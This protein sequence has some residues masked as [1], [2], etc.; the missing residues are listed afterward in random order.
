MTADDVLSALSVLRDAGA[1]VWV[2]GGWGIDALVG[3]QTRRHRD[4]DLMHRQDQEQTVVTA[5][6][7]AGFAETVDWRPVRFVVADPHGREIDLH[8]LV[9]AADGSAVQA[10]LDPH[11]PFGYPAACFV[12][13]T[14]AG[15]AVPCLSAE[16]QVYFHQGY[17]PADRDRHDMAQLRRV[18]GVATHF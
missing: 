12:S 9:F 14:I 15:T 10:S 18:F 11:R 6:A 16:Q 8:P 13:G 2:G 17:E 4:L 3:E 7:E 1:D 5:L